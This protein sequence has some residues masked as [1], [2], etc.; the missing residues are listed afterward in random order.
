MRYRGSLREH[1]LS[2][3]GWELTRSVPGVPAFC[4]MGIVTDYGIFQV[5]YTDGNNHIVKDTD[6]GGH[7]GT[8]PSDS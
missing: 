3:C 4:P 2:N 8:G 7:D 1:W 6:H 5:Q